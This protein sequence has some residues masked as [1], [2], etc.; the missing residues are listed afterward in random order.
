MAS[1]EDCFNGTDDDCDGLPDCADSECT[2][3][4]ACAPEGM[5]LGFL[6]AAGSTCPTGTTPDA[7]PLHQNPQSGSCQGC[8]CGAV[9]ATT[10]VATVS[11]TTGSCPSGGTPIATYNFTTINSYTC[12]SNA[13]SYDNWYGFHATFT[14]TPGTCPPNGSPKPS[15]L[16]W[17]SDAVFCRILRSG[18]GCGTGQVCLPR[19]DTVPTAKLCDQIASGSCQAS[20][21]TQTW[22]TGADDGRSCGACKCTASGA[23]CSNVKVQFGSD[24]GCDAY[25]VVVG[26]GETACS[27]QQYG[28]YSPEA[29]LIGTPTNATC[30]ASAPLQGSILPVGATTLCCA[31]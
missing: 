11:G 6:Q 4:A 21:T 22:Y 29:K 12:S 25:I 18:T 27:P 19:N 16:A 7:Q 13:V 15:M 3:P 26:D 8:G 24:Y 5:A 30:A 20:Q 9:S 1:T 23:G 14:T 31:P 17:N 2:G 10:C 28:N